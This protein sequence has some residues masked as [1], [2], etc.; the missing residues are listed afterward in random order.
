MI[1]VDSRIGS[2]ELADTIRAMHVEVEEWHK[3]ADR[4]REDARRP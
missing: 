3:I 4:A 2:I 1:S